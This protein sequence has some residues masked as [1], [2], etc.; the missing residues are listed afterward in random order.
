MITKK[1]ETFHDA[2][3][4]LGN[5]HPYVKSY[6]QY[7]NTGSGEEK[8]VIAYLKLRIIAA[9]LN[10]GWKAKATDG[11]IYYPWFTFLPIEKWC[12]LSDEE[13][14]RVIC[15]V[16]D[17]GS[18]RVR[19]GILGTIT[20]FATSSGKGVRLSYLTED[21]AWYAGK[22]FFEEYIDYLFPDIFTNISRE[23]VYLMP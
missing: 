9:A 5:E 16:E 15:R 17:T 2:Y 19:Y 18:R 7:V 20:T 14:R 23:E 10:E 21:L 6:E 12:K 3:C 22:Q 8:D 13:R 1:I 11:R 4:A